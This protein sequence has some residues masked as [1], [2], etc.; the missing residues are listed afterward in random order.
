MHT[1]LFKIFALYYYPLL[2]RQL[3][4]MENCLKY[5]ESMMQKEIKTIAIVLN[6]VAT[7]SHWVSAR[8]A[9]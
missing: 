6:L 4:I 7:K 1:I 5:R 3:A 8:L 2:I 9:S